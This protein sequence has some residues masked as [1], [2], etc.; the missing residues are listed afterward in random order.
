[1]LRALDHGLDATAIVAIYDTVAVGAIKALSERGLRVPGDVSVTGFDDI[2]YARYCVPGLT[3]VSQP[4]E[5]IVRESTRILLDII[6]GS[7]RGAEIIRLH[8]PVIERGSVC[9]PSAKE[10]SP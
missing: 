8:G 10:T 2:D 5:Q 9:A 6:A 3:T 1:M 7:A 4:L